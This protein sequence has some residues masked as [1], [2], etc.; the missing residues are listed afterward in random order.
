MHNYQ[1]SIG[2]HS[3][4]LYFRGLICYLLGRTQESKEWLDKGLKTAEDC[5]WKWLWIKGAIEL[6]LGHYY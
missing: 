3:L 2:E 1:G 5:S 4:S 6:E